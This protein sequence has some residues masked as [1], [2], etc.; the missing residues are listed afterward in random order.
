METRSVGQMKSKAVMLGMMA[1]ILFAAQAMAAKQPPAS[2]VDIN[3]AGVEELMTI[4]GI[5]ATK[6]QAIVAY[7]TNTPFTTT[8]DLVNVK[9]IGEKLFA[10]IAPYV[11]VSG[12]AVH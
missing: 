8:N 11:V 3:K 10:R 1:V 4:P 2:P 5:G 6:A 12:V 9:G 7:R